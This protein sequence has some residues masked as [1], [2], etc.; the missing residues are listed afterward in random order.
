MM[1]ALSVWTGL[2]LSYLTISAAMVFVAG[3]VRG[4]AG[5]GLSAVLMASIVVFIPPV[6][7]IPVCFLLEAAASLAM[8]KG[9]LRDADR[10]TAF[11]L[12]VC[13]AVGVPLGLAATTSI[14]PDLSKLVALL[15]V[16]SLTIL[17]LFKVS[18]T[19]FS[20]R[21]ALPVTGLVAGVVTGLASIGGMVIALYVLASSHKARTM[22]GSLVLFLFCGMITSV[23]TLLFFGLLGEAAIHRGLLFAPIVLAG[24]FVGSK[25][26]SRSLE[27]T[28]KRWCLCLLTVLAITGLVRVVFF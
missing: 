10:R 11:T 16:L 1:Q 6:E 8:F 7:L 19:L 5:F 26:F 18:L 22:R 9:G 15:L 27:H 12:A 3:L 14:P 17:Q 25:L 13:S 28:Y 20:T 21:Y 24:V 4:F 2:P 23:V